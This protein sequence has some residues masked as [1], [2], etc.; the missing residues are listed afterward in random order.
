MP[1]AV[2]QRSHSERPQS[3]AADQHVRV[4]IGRK[5]ALGLGG[6]AAFLFLWAGA[7][8]WFVATRD[9]LAQRVFVRETELQ[10]SYEDRIAALK[11]ELERAVTQTMVERNGVAARL[12]SVAKRQ[13]D[14]ENR[15]AWLGRL[16][17]R[18]TGDSRSDPAAAAYER[19]QAAERRPASASGSV[20]FPKPAPAI[21]PFALRLRDTPAAQDAPEASDAGTPRP[22]DRLSLIEGALDG[23]ATDEIRLVDGVR[24]RA[25]SQL[26]RLRIAISATG[27]DTD[28]S[29][30]P[31]G[32]GGPLVPLP[33]TSTTGV[34]GP[35]AAEL[36]AT[37]DELDRALAATR[38]LP[39]GR[40]LAGE[41]EATSPF[42][43]RLDPF[44]RS[45]ALHTG[46]DFRA[47][48]G[49]PIRATAAGKVTVAEYTG[50]YGNMVEIDHGGGYVTR[51]GHMSAF[52]VSPG[53]HVEAG[54]TVG[55]VGS[56]GRSTGSHLHYE[57]RINGEP[58]NPVRFLAAGTQLA[59]MMAD[60]R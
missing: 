46:T 13:A 49:S 15:Q 3:F 51:Y 10:Y 45:A 19:P 6:T 47:E 30:T 35:L 25:Q 5:A 21:E 31:K 42:G 33:Q 43:Y 53:E 55:R 12:D 40:P 26:A 37:F 23:V 59:G 48:A 29:N 24:Q 14:I 50:G 1:S 7:A 8:T 27:F 60:L 4:A 56:T 52:A 16:A 54:E 22:R 57:T 28:H 9:D 44:T 41:M 58:V 39:L 32:L 38:S 11:N 2:P 20:A 17:S 18:F 36:E 34:F